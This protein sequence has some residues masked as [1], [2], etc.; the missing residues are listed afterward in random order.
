MRARWLLVTLT[1]LVSTL[2]HAAV[3]ETTRTWNQAEEDLYSAWVRDHWT[4]DFLERPGTP[5]QDILVDCA[6]TGYA[7]RIIYSAERALPFAMQDISGGRR[8]ISQSMNRW[9]SLP[10]AQ[11]LRSFIG[12]VQRFGNSHTTLPNDTYPLAMNRTA[13]RSGAVLVAHPEHHH[14]WTVKE[15]DQVGIPH[16]IYSS[17]PAATH[18]M[19]FNGFPSF[20]FLF[21]DHDHYRPRSNAGFR[22]FRQPQYIGIP[23][24]QVPGFS[25]EQ[26]SLPEGTDWA[27][28]AQQRLWVVPETPQQGLTRLWNSACELARLRV[29]AVQQGL[30]FLRT[31]PESECESYEDWDNFSTPNRDE[32]LQDAFEELPRYTRMVQGVEG[33]RSS[34]EYR[35]AREVIE[36][37]REGGGGD[38]QIND[39]RVLTLHELYERSTRNRLSSDP[40]D[41]FEARWGDEGA[42]HDPRARRCARHYAH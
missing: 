39:R 40:H 11:R 15:I 25:L 22:W 27:Y 36:G 18:L 35:R 41:P 29:T 33:V 23:A 42:S 13:I 5:Y 4:V 3:W 14:S 31:Q 8:T 1:L 10:P 17:R 21:L 19:T 28:T 6:D 32:R 26:Y 30:D 24:S 16:L 7:M 2:S 38:V 37:G 20:G 34:M 12:Y 9:D